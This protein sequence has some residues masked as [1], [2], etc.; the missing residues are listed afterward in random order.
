MYADEEGKRRSYYHHSCWPNEQTRREEAEKERKALKELCEYIM[1]LHG[2]RL[3]PKSFFPFLQD[4]RNGTVRFQGPVQSKY[5]Q[6]I[7]YEVIHEAYRLCQDNIAWAKRNKRFSSD[8]AEV[9]YGFA[10][11]QNNI[12]Q[13]YESWQ[14]KQ[15][16]SQAVSIATPQGK[17]VT[18]KKR[19]QED[20]SSIVE[21]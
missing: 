20:I 6:G 11:I 13:A 8:L 17:E 15:Q 18:Y 21:D 14:R 12:N 5:K 19:T 10:I 1:E 4:L 2:F 3:L 9:K 7:P 16:A